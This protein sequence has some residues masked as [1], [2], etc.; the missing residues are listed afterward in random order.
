MK[1]LFILL[2]SG[3]LMGCETEPEPAFTDQQLGQLIVVGFRGTEVNKN[4]QIIK[5]L[6]DLQI[7]GVILFDHDHELN[8]SGRNIESPD[9]ML[10]LASDLITNSPVPPII[11]VSQD[12]GPGSPL[13]EKYGF[14]AYPSP[15]YLSRAAEEDTTR[16]YARN[17]AQEFMVVGVNTNFAPVMNPQPWGGIQEA[18]EQT[19]HI[20]KEF[21]TEGIFSVPKYFPGY[22]SSWSPG[23]TLINI[24]ET[25]T[26]EHLAPFKHLLENRITMGLMTSHSFNAKLDS[27]WPATLSSA[28][29]NGLL[30]DSLGYDGVVFSDD[31][32][33]PAIT[34]HY[35]METVIAQALNAGVDI[36]VFGNNY[37]Y[38][39]QL[40]QN[41]IDTI[42]KVIASGK[43]S[44]ETVQQALDRVTRLKEEVI[45]ELCTCLN[46]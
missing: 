18:I 11:A 25:W 8:Q 38:D 44:P 13:K 2:L 23:D 37:E 12:G 24:T 41:V 26:E 35:D 42:Q 31:L 16:H 29:I 28:T 32:Q 6:R 33:K 7:G 20:L 40:S 46:L 10:M 27:L 9:Q 34:A 36:L 30:R 39:E 1:K 3:I 21:D 14:P 45:A 22:G 43:V 15:A 17:M 5:D 4:H 19:N